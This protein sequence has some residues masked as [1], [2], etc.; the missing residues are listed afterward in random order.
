MLPKLIEIGPFSIYSFGV[1]AMLG[2]L[3]PALLLRREFIRHKL[4]PDLVN[5]LVIAMILAGFGGARLYYILE[6]WSRFVQDP[7]SLI[8]TGAGLAWYGGFFG[9]TAA[10]LWVIRW[11]KLPLGL[12]ADMLAPL[13]VLGYA[14]GRMGCLL[15]ADGDYG[16]PTDLPWGM[17]FPEGAMPPHLNPRIQEILGTT[18]V[19]LDIKVHPTPLYEILMLLPLFFFLWRRRTRPHT[20]GSQFGLYLVLIGAE[21]FISEFWRM[22]PKVWGT[23]L[24]VPQLYSL[25]TALAGVIL[26]LWLR[27]R[28]ESKQRG[29]PQR[30]KRPQKVAT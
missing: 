20:V 27:R 2:F 26:L 24:T 15:A 8:F 10:V 13:L 16:P 28:K 23:W 18:N 25:V 14:F 11:K 9:A 4:D 7:M 29:R 12:T 30:Q 19:P 6:H 1:M 5:T 3:V 21:R 17:S 22:T